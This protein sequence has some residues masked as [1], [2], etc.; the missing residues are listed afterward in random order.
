MLKVVANIEFQQGKAEEAYKLADELVAEVKAK[1]DYNIAY[2]WYKNVE[3]GNKI[4]FIEEWPS[5]EKLD[6]HMATD[7]FVTIF[8][9][10][11]ELMVGEM[12][13]AIYTK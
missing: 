1:E 9:K 10:I 4:V 8:G 3:D 7:H 2:E 13:V 11:Q 6:V 12:G 5:Q